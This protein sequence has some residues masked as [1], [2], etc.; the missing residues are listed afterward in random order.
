MQT[1]MALAVWPRSQRT[2]VSWGRAL[3]LSQTQLVAHF[4][5]FGPQVANRMRIRHRLAAELGD[6]L[7]AAVCQSAGFAQIVREQANPFDAKIAHDRGRQAEVPAIG[8]EPEGMIGLDRVETG[9]LQLVSLQR[10]YH[11][12]SAA[13]L[14]CIDQEPAAFFGDGLPGPLPLRV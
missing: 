14:I 13:F 10:R 7:D 6:H 9:M 1:V 12:D 2:Q 5:L 11:A 8:L 3:A 4:F